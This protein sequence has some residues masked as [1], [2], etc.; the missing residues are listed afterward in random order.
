MNPDSHKAGAPAR[1]TWSAKVALAFAPL[2]LMFYG[3]EQAGFL[4]GRLDRGQVFGRDFINY[5]TGS[6]LLIEGHMRAVFTQADYA[7]AVARLWGPGLATHNFSYPPSL[8]AF[9]G[10]TGALPYGWAIALWSLAGLGLLLMAAGPLGRRPLTALAIVCSPAVMICLD[11]GQNG[12]LTGALLVGGLSLC[13]SRPLLGGVL[14][15]LATFKPQLGLLI[16]LALLAAGRWRTIAGATASALALL[17][18]S[19]VIAGPDAWRWYLTQAAP[20]Q[21]LLLEHRTGTFQVMMTSPF[22]AGRLTGLNLAQ[23]Y[24]LQAAASLAAAA[25][26]V[27]W[28]RRIGRAGAAIAPLDILMLLTAGF[29][30]SPYGFNYDMAGLAVAI[31]LAERADPGLGASAAWRWAAAALWSAPLVMML[32]PLALGWQGGAT[33]P[34]GPIL[35]LLGLALLVAAMARRPADLPVPA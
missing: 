14:I 16:P 3:Y 6:R 25:L 24:A 35:T 8:F 27:W 23:S 9:I 29:V 28:F 7:A 33:I 31:L 5:W 21:R 11:D 34:V 10:W 17:A 19:L 26:V 12:L 20:F 2:S 15:G 13:S 32:V 1:L 22:M 18:V 30:A 4:H